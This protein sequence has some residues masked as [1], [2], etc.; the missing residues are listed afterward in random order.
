MSI[1]KKAIKGVFWSVIQNWG[2]QTGSL[3]VFLILARLL[4]PKDFGLVALSNLFITFINIFITQG[5][6]QALIQRQKLDQEH[7][8]T[9][10]WTQVA[11][12][13]LLTTTSFITAGWVANL[14][15]EP[16]LIPLIKYLSVIF[17]L[18]AF[19]QVQIALLKRKFAFKT[20]ATRALFGIFMGGFVG[21]VMAIA[22][23][24]VWSLVAQELVYQGVGIIVLW[25]ASD[26]QPRFRVSSPHFK[27]L[28]HFGVHVL[29]FQLVN[30]FNQRT[31]T[32]LIGYFLGAKTLGY[33]A[34]AQRILQVMTQL[35]VGTTNQVA[36]STFS[37]L[38]T[39]LNRLREAFYQVTQ[40]TSLIAFPT[41]LGMIA[42]TPEL[43]ILLF[44]KQWLPAIP[45][46]QILALAGLLR[47]VSFFNESVFMA[48]DKPSWRF[49]LG[50]LNAI[51]NVIACLVAV[52]WGLM[53]IA[54]AYVISDYLVFPISQW[55]VSQ[56]I[57]TPI[58][59]YLRQLIVPLVC[60]LIMVVVILAVKYLLRDL[61]NSQ[62][63]LVSCTVMGAIAY[64]LTIR[65]LSPKLWQ[66]S[67]ELAILAISR[68]K[69]HNL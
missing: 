51:L 38:Q 41:F 65:W 24:G 14:F 68:V 1:K 19:S 46:M 13:F 47:S 49:R 3:L 45:I 15:Q 52:R 12:G 58:L 61:L 9:A 4:Q 29:G 30:F 8:D 63:S 27:E 54:V 57:Q 59:T 53:A 43:V 64:G 60:A 39:D 35:L 10:F 55:A 69:S 28:F 20:L 56:L 17:F 22:G 25:R 31:D 37:R 50:L 11:I 67:L 5:F 18:N 44:G 32:L 2:S 16:Q 48:M 6:S 7:L 40:L 26:W 33:Y 34:I 62:A 42:M 23:F 36:L 66:Q 21:V